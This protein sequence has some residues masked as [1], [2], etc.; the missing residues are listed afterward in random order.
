LVNVAGTLISHRAGVN[1]L[2]RV[3]G[4]ILSRHHSRVSV[5]VMR[6]T[7]L[8]ASLILPSL[9]LLINKSHRKLPNID[10]VI[11]IILILVNDVQICVLHGLLLLLFIDV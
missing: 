10:G 4:S 9:T 1:R 5:L 8:L 11:W 3:F 6:S 7:S 2:P